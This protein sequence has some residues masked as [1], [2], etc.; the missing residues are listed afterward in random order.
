MATAALPYM[1]AIVGRYLREWPAVNDLVGNRVAG[2]FP[3]STTDPWVVVRLLDPNNAGASSEFE[4]LVEY[5]LQIDCYAG[6]GE[7]GADGGGQDEAWAIAATVRAALV[8]M[9]SAVLEEV[10]VTAV[11]FSSMPRV[12]DTDFKPA[13]Q[14]YALTAHVY[15]HPADG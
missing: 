3:S 11:T 14:R 2:K 7:G 4:H 6:E 5:M 9:P 15:A 13:R 1:E 12:Q 10:D 8:E